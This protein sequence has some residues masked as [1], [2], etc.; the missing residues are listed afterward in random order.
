MPEEKVLNAETWKRMSLF[1]V[2]IV[3]AFDWVAMYN[4]ASIMITSAVNAA[5]VTSLPCNG[6]SPSVFGLLVIST[7][8]ISDS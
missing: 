7:L 6:Y 1:W 5:K 2:T 3:F 8:L 4:P